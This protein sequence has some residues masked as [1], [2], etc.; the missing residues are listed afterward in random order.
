MFFDY[1]SNLPYGCWS[2]QCMAEIFPDISGK[3]GDMFYLS[4][5]KTCGGIYRLPREEKLFPFIRCR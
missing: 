5:N 1:R 4:L 2:D 3:L